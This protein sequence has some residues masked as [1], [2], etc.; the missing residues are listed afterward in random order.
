[1]LFVVCFFWLVLLFCAFFVLFLACA[2]LLCFFF[3]F[4]ILEVCARK[5]PLELAP[6]VSV[7]LLNIYILT[8]EPQLLYHQEN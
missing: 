7:E 5:C 6:A 1:M 2:F 3:N 4:Q 8:G